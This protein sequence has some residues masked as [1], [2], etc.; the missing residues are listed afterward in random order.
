MS[1]KLR[2]CGSIAPERLDLRRC[3]SGLQ[4]SLGAQR[5]LVVR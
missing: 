4:E 3:W 2:L 5:G 1:L